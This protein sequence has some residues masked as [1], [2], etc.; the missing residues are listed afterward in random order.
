MKNVLKSLAFFSATGAV[1]IM[2]CSAANW[3]WENVIED[4]LDDLY[5]HRLH[6]K[7]ES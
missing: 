2:G 3:L 4:K 7:K 1:T 6:G 5:Y